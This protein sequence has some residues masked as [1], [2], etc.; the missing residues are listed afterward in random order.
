MS[1]LSDYQ[2]ASRLTAENLRTVA[3]TLPVQKLSR[4]TLPQ[5]RAVVD[6]VAQIVPA[7]NVPGMILSGLMRLPGRRL[8]PERV[9]QDINVLFSSVEQLLDRA[10][11]GAF[12]AG[13]AAIL[14]AYQNLLKLAGKD[15]EAPF[16][17]GMWQ[18]Y[19]EY[20]LRD[21]TA[22][23]CNETHG[24]DSLLEQHKIRLG[25]V[26]RL[27]AWVMAAVM[28]LHQYDALLENEWIERR[29]L[30]LLAEMMPAD[31]GGR[32]YRDWELMRPYRRG[33]GASED[34]PAY[35]RK[36]FERF[37]EN[38]MPP[39]LWPEWEKRLQ[40]AMAQELPA[41]QRQMS[42]LSYLDAGRYRETRRSYPLTEAQIGV[43][44]R[45][46]YHLLPVC[47]AG[48]AHPADV[49][50]VRAQVAALLASPSAPTA[51]LQPL[52][53]LQ[54]SALAELKPRLGTLARQA[55]DEL[56]FVP[57]LINM[58]AHD[59]RLP[60]TELR[61]SE[62]GVGS[63]AL[64]IFDTGQS[65]VFDQSHIYFDGAWGAALA[66]ILTNE[67]LSW[68]VYLSKLPPAL[69]ASVRLYRRLDAGLTEADL[70]LV[71]SAPQ[72]CTEAA[73]ESE[74]VDLR[75]MKA[76]RKLF[77]QRGDFHLTVNDLL[78]L[79]RA[80]HAVTYRPSATLLE[81]IE[82][83]RERHPK[84][85][86]S[87]QQTL[88]QEGINPAILIPMD[89]SPRSPRDRLYP[90]SLEVP[91]KDLD[92]LDLHRQAI[93]LL[94]AYER[95]SG[96]RAALYAEFD[97]VQR[98]YLATLAGF[99]AFLGKLK[100][101]AGQGESMSIGALKLLAHLPVHI[102]RLLDQLPDRFEL[103]N[104]LLKG[105]EVFSNIG[106]VAPSSSLRRFATA[107]DDN[108]RKELAWGVLTDAEGVMHISL[109]D[110][111]PHVQALHDVGQQDL[112]NLI[113]QDY[114]NAYV[115]GLNVFVRELARITLASRETRTM[116][117]KR[118]RFHA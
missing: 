46:G 93:H 107:K 82:R 110:F 15:L 58:D 59:H 38:A 81:K 98:V 19:T 35:R 109:R 73:A 49:L 88:S 50:Q 83:L 114:L 68:A 79:Y 48:K 5:I 28:C 72:A 4:L 57:I 34:Y 44:Y 21:D 102:Q 22:R 116:P 99:G 113:A 1:R 29:A 103:L 77:A 51:R 91:L 2:Q 80:I 53:R 90:L 10:V 94:D 71:E 64:T 111:R 86:A 36:Q 101:I 24:F 106:A 117:K 30:N 6:L 84:L 100:Q 23:H 39:G 118:E 42:I 87:I 12:F 70:R 3:E 47:G 14:W 31:N 97:R 40:Q 108:R 96:D 33:A 78:V 11:Y 85:A 67:A 76:L 25:K 66:E 27:T 115:E 13:P 20:A 43:I 17:E 112:A 45:G 41:Y 74:G 18:F 9:H 26:E 92:L 56:R 32:L 8:T 69:P 60:L 16:P 63:H 104:N 55:L 7:G 105:Q 65:F 95:A 52:A 37:L 54:R 75:A 89:A 62:R 61:Q